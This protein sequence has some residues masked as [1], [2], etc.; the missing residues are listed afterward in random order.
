MLRSVFGA[1]AHDPH[2]PLV[3]VVHPDPALAV[4]VVAL[5]Q[6]SQST[7]DAVKHVELQSGDAVD[8]ESVL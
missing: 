5:P 4:Y 2:E 6:L 1:S 3:Y 8:A 7:A